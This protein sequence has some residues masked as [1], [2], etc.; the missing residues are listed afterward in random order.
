MTHNQAKQANETLELLRTLAPNATWHMSY[1][2]YTKLPQFTAINNG[3][4]EFSMFK[5]E[6]DRIIVKQDNGITYP[7]YTPRPHAEMTA[8]ITDSKITDNGMIVSNGVPKA[9]IKEEMPRVNFNN[10]IKFIRNNLA[11]LREIGA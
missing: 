9:N 1:N 3:G 6:G 8:T 10:Y 11:I 5:R 4:V 2:Y 7:S